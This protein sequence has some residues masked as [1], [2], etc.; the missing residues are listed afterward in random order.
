MLSLLLS[1][2]LQSGEERRIVARLWARRRPRD[3]ASNRD[4][5]RDFGLVPGP[6]RMRVLS[7]GRWS[8]IPS[9]RDPDRWRQ[10]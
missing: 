7:F 3:R 8:L 2:L 6:A 5:R 9:P 4:G 10:V 1:H